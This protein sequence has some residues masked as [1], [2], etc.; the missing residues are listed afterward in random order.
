MYEYYVVYVQYCG[1]V[2]AVTGCG[3]S[4]CTVQY[5]TAQC[6]TVV[7]GNRVRYERAR[8]SMQRTMSMT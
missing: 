7:Y 2:H 8:N 1:M 6:S 4:T 3:T 5:S